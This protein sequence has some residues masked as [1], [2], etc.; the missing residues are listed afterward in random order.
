MSLLKAF[1]RQAANDTS[2]STECLVWPYGKT[3]SSRMKGG[4]YG[5][6]RWN[7]KMRRA[8]C[9]VWS[10]TNGPIPQGMVVMHECDNPLCCNRTHLSL[11]TQKDNMVDAGKKGRLSGRR[12][13]RSGIG[14]YNT[15]TSNSQARLTWNDVYDLRVMAFSGEPREMLMDVFAISQT[16]LYE[17]LSFK[18]WANTQRDAA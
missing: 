7:G 2:G 11:G 9:V 18:N 6:L 15:G 17:I 1:V 13:H 12:G 16:T 3:A 14:R 4:G 10:L 8:H 5:C